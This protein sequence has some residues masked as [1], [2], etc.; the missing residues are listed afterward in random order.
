MTE[1]FVTTSGSWEQPATSLGATNV[2]VAEPW[3]SD[4]ARVGKCYNNV[5]AAIA[6]LGGEAAYG[7]AL[8]DF[9]PHRARQGKH[10]APLYRRWLNH[11]LWRDPAGKVWEVTPNAVVDNHS[12]REFKPTEYIPDAAA[13][14]EIITSEEWYTRPARYVPWRPEG[15]VTADCL[16]KAQH[17]QDDNERNHWLAEALRS[18]A[19]LGFRPLEWKV[20]MVGRRM[21][22]IWL[23]AE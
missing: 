21:G 6:R 1:V 17:A 5:Q 2:F 18:I 23:I 3:P 16:N 7:W 11:V 20:E 4:E 12:V 14:F 8:T 15:V 10:P 9:G 22:S 13:T 19:A